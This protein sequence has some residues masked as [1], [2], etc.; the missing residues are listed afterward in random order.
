MIRSLLPALLLFAR[1]GA[2]A[3]RVEPAPA[4]TAQ[5]SFHFEHPGLS[6]PK[7]T[8][9]VDESGSGRYEADQTSTA[10]PGSND[11]AT[12]QIDRKIAL[13]P[14]TTRRIFAAARDLDRFN[15]VCASAAKNIADTGTKTLQY[16]GKSGD[17]SCV[18]NFSENKRVVA[19][20]DLFLA[21][22]VTLDIGRKLDFDHRFDRL[23]LDASMASLVE[24]VDAG[25]A[26]ELG[27]IYTTLDSI[28]QDSELLE[29]VRLSATKLLRQASLPPEAFRN[30]GASNGDK[31]S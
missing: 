31:S 9:I 7:F 12:Q 25:R 15:I 27:T 30:I 14:A 10:P 8:L 16:T 24:Q 19:L 3:Q 26:T 21:I 2:P 5:V 6:V 28:A 22:A 13:S 17:G 29:R 4:A 20:T 1:I 11:S 23:G 18:Y